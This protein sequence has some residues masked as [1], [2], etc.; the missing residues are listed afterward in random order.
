[1]EILDRATLRNQLV[2]WQE[3]T[4]SDE[5]IWNLALRCKAQTQPEDQVVRDLID[6]LCAL[7]EDLVTRDDLPVFFDALDNP[8][9][10]EEMSVNLLW[11]YADLI[12]I[13]ARRQALA[14][15]PLYGP[16]CNG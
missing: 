1:M 15:D 3:Q 16:Y 6:I 9:E 8:P 2:Q 12:D 7:P 4:L 5:Q 13:V 11:N 10:E 14:N